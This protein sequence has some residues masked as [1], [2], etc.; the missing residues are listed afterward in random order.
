M[1]ALETPQAED[2]FPATDYEIAFPQADGHNVDTLI[3]RLRGNIKLNRHDQA[4][5]DFIESLRLGKTIRLTIL[6]NVT[7]KGD[8]YTIDTDQNETVAH[9]VSLT[10]D[11]IETA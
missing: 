3:V 5:V 8:A 9:T 11:M 4:S 6:A 1:S 7:S 2:L 10:A